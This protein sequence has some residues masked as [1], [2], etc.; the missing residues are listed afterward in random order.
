MLVKLTDP[1]AEFLH[2][3][4]TALKD[5]KVIEMARMT[6]DQV[7]LLEQTHTNV[8]IALGRED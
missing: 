5:G 2:A 7:R 1:Q 3:M 6:R 4:L 8:A